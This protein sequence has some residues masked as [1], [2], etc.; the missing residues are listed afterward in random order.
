MKKTNKNMFSAESQYKL[1]GEN[2]LAKLKSQYGN[3]KFMGSKEHNDTLEQIKASNMYLTSKGKKPIN[4]SIKILKS[5]SEL[6]QKQN[7]EAALNTK[8]EQR[9]SFFKRTV[10]NAVGYGLS[11]AARSM[12]IK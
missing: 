6:F 8:K 4:G 3:V 2:A 9:K 10:P 11:N 7:Q 12:Y 5:G 1:H